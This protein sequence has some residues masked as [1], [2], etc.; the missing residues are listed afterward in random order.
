MHN[1]AF[2]RTRKSIAPLKAALCSSGEC[3]E[4]YGDD[5]GPFFL[6]ACLA[7]DGYVHGVN[8]CYYLN[9]PTGWVLDTESG[10][11][12]G[13]PMVFYPKGSSWAK[14]TTVIY[15]RNDLF[16]PDLIRSPSPIP[17]SA[18]LGLV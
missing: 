17:I 5:S 14:A 11:R 6:F 10:K 2:Q 16:V 9:E 15:T 3:H 8:H 18:L 12:Q 13:L 4:T 7:E 1:C